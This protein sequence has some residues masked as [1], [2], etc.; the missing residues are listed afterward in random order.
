[1]SAL[2]GNPDIEQIPKRDVLSGLRDAS[3]ATGKGAYHKTRHGFDILERI[4]PG[5][6]RR[7]S[8]HAE[9]LFT[10]LLA[11]LEMAG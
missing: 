2:P 5:D 4:D 3:R 8:G 11:R 6:V 1:V 7:R 9:A 10:L